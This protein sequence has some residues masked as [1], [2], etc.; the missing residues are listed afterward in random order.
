MKEAHA[1]HGLARH[2]GGL[3]LMQYEKVEK[4]NKEGKT[5]KLVLKC[6]MARGL[7]RFVGSCL[8]K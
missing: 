5:Q 2:H 1:Y 4:V 6:V 7:L 3:I 8:P